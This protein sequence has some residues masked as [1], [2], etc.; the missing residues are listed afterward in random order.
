M[1]AIVIHIKFINP[2]FSS[3][4]LGKVLLSITAIVIVILFMGTA[5]QPSISYNAYTNGA[6]TNLYKYVSFSIY[7]NSEKSFKKF[8]INTSYIQI[9]EINI[10]IL[11]TQYQNKFQS[12]FKILTFINDTISSFISYNNNVKKGII[13][14]TAFENNIFSYYT[15]KINESISSKVIT[16]PPGTSGGESGS[17]VPVATHSSGSCGWVYS[18]NNYNTEGLID[19]LI[20]GATISALVI[21]LETGVLGLP[22]A[23]VL[24]S[25]VVAVAAVLNYINWSGGYR[26]IYVAD[27]TNYFGI[28]SGH[29]Y[30]IP[31]GGANP[32]P[33]GY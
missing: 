15:G 17:F 26:R 12:G 27:T 14:I 16:G 33:D 2:P 25:A 5:M 21:L 23:T 30:G 24:T 28:L 19:L 20:A 8:E 32:V 11:K 29:P 3:M 22:V 13:H 1:T 6:N 10:T 18:F 7:S 4:E 31:W 9:G